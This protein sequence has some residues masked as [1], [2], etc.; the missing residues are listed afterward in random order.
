MIQVG[1]LGS[2][3]A[4]RGRRQ[5][6]GALAL[7][8]GVIGLPGGC[9]TYAARESPAARAETMPFVQTEGTVVLGVDPYVQADRSEAIFDE[10][11]P[12]A[13]VIPL[14]VVVRNLGERPAA[15]QVRNFRLVLPGQEVAG[16]R[17]GAE[18]AALFGRR[19]GVASG[20]SSGIGMLG[21]LGGAIGGL[22][23][24]AVGGAAA[25]G[26]DGSEQDAVAARRADYTRKELKDV[27]LGPDEATR[28]FLFFRVPDG[29]PAFDAATLVLALPADG[30]A[31]GSAKVALRGLGYRGGAEAGE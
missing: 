7:A 23:A 31:A 9:T 21:G 22:A 29:M 1:Q 26:I 25:G 17:P 16:P 13:A 8:L 20:A 3:S 6:I 5:A 12:A 19:T 30:T 10:D 24:K 27:V 28:G 14:Q 11:L 4:R 2:T 18:V 15:I